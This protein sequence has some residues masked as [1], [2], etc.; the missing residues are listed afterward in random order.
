MRGGAFVTEILAGQSQR[1]VAAV[2]SCPSPNHSRRLGNRRKGAQGCVISAL[3]LPWVSA[4]FV[5]DKRCRAV[6]LVYMHTWLQ[7]T[8]Y[9]HILSIR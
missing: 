2:A 6:L 5:A 4:A 8:C 9:G 3:R 1:L 7:S